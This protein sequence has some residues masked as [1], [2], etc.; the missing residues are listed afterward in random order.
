[1]SN[2]GGDPFGNWSAPAGHNPNNMHQN[3]VKNVPTGGTF[4]AMSL[5][6]TAFQPFTPFQ[7]TN[8][9]VTKSLKEHGVEDKDEVTKYKNLITELKKCHDSS[10]GVIDLDIFKKVGEL[11]IC[12][13]DSKCTN[14]V[15]VNRSGQDLEAA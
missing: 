5:S 1:M 13:K 4:K 7:P 12:Q 10:T 9:H 14:K 15:Y 11:G 2:T 3:K 8:D 6:A